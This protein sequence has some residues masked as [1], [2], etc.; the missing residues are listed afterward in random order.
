MA[1]FG[2][3]EKYTQSVGHHRGER[4]WNK[5]WLVSVGWVISYAN[6]WEDHS[7]N[8]GMPWNS[9]DASVCVI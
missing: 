7:N 2:F 1:L 8:W 6:E 5:M 3:R 9:L 4:L